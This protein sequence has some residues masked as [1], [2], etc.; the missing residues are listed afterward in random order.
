MYDGKL[1]KMDADD[2]FTGE[3]ASLNLDINFNRLFASTAL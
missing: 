3:I 1:T 2:A